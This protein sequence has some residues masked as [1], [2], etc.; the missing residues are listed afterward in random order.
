[1]LNEWGLD[2]FKEIFYD[3]KYL[4]ILSNYKKI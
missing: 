4:K 2:D 3:Q 1:M